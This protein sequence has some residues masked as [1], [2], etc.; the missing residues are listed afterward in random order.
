MVILRCWTYCLP[1]S[2]RTLAL[3][4][5]HSLDEDDYPNIADW[6]IRSFIPDDL[7][8]SSQPVLDWLA[9]TGCTW[10]AIHFD[11]DTVDSNEIVRRAGRPPRRRGPPD[12]CRRSRCG[13]RCRVHRGG[14]LP[15]AGHASSVDPAGAASLIDDPST[16]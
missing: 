4:G 15:A 8:H 6:G 1:P 5:L 14:V 9:A 3:V 16:N 10:V 7:R 11:V 12:R 2:R 13:G